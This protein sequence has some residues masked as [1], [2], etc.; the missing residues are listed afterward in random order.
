MRRSACRPHVDL[1]SPPPDLRFSR[2][3]QGAGLRM[4]IFFAYSTYSATVQGST[5]KSVKCESCGESYSYPMSRVASGSDL[6]LF[7]S[8]KSHE[9]SLKQAQ[10]NLAKALE[11]DHDDI[12]CPACGWHQTVHV[13]SV[14]RRS[15]PD[16]KNLAGAFFIF[17]NLA[18]GVIIFFWLLFMLVSGPTL[19]KA[20]SVLTCAAVVLSIATPGFVLRGL[21]SLLV[22]TYRPNR[23]FHQV[24]GTG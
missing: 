18:L 10:G 8:S 4:F 3:A 6:A 16:L 12:P 11:T 5:V 9:R 22:R 19:P 13:D 17:A 1:P 24:R 7:S 23:K 14:R 20:S 15:Y 2:L 21:R